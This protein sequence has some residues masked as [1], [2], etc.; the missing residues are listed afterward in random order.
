L[1]FSYRSCADA[2]P[3]KQQPPR[4]NRTTERALRLISPATASL[5][6]AQVGEIVVPD[7]RPE[8]S[9]KRSIGALGPGD[10]DLL[11]V[12]RGSSASW[13]GVAHWMRTGPGSATRALLIFTGSKVSWRALTVMRTEPSEYFLAR[14]ATGISLGF[15]GRAWGWAGRRGC[16]QRRSR[17]RS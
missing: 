8:A 4:A 6:F 17:A 16:R 5:Q 14:G 3:Y 1:E 9:G 13:A 10:G 15:F 11:A 12:G 2:T 7:Q